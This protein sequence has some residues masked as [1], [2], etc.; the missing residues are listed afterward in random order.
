MKSEK[1]TETDLASGVISDD[2]SQ[3]H[4]MEQAKAVSK[5]LAMMTNNLTNNTSENTRT[6][7][8]SLKSVVNEALCPKSVKVSSL[9][10][11]TA[12]STLIVWPRV[13]IYT[14]TVTIP[15]ISFKRAMINVEADPEQDQGLRGAGGLTISK[16]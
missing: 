8:L 13:K 10:I 2:L 16:D 3:V 12:H 15:G 14:K 7:R 11:H 1:R 6:E 9:T 5:E 4:C